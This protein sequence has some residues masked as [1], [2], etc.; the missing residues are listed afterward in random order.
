VDLLITVVLLALWALMWIKIGSWFWN[1]PVGSSGE[2]YIDFWGRQAFDVYR[3]LVG[4][5]CDDLLELWIR[6]D[7]EVRARE[8][9]GSPA[10]AV[11]AAAAHAWAIAMQ[12]L[13]ECP[14]LAIRNVIRT[15]VVHYDAI[16]SAFEKSVGH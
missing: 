14:T 1:R 7:R 5:T 8:A 6:A 15:R 12:L 13:K 4:R 16:H 11:V 2:S 3:W 10:T 9:D